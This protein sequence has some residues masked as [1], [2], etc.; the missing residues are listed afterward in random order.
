MTRSMTRSITTMA[1]L[2]GLSGLVAALVACEPATVEFPPDLF[3]VDTG[4]FLDT[5]LDTGADT[6]TEAEPPTSGP[7]AVSIDRIALDCT[8]ADTA[9]LAIVDSLG[10]SGTASL[11]V[12]IPEAVTGGPVSWETHPLVLVDSD[13]DGAWDRY[14][15]G[16]L[17]AGVPA[18][19]AQPGV[20]T[21]LPCPHPPAADGSAPGSPGDPSF[22]V[23]LF[24]R[25]GDPI[26]CAVSGPAAI[27]A[28]AEL[29]D[30]FGLASH[31][32]SCTP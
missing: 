4:L 9:W 19:E 14:L 32:V 30:S 15:G 26:D 16:P 7:V 1:V 12:Q 22:G 31:G 11:L 28:A 17:A 24:D 18:A 5:G 27:A 25:V 8:P 13:P 20:S 29:A 2:A 21:A 23:V 10:W 6:D 3:F